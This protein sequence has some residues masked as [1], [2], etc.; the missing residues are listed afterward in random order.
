MA[1]PSLYSKDDELFPLMDKA[2]NF[3][4]SGRQVM[5]LLG[6]SGSG[7]S[8]FSRRLEQELWKQYDNSNDPIPLLISLPTIDT[9]ERD[10]VYK[11]LC[12]EGFGDSHIKDLQQ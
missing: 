6:D 2:K 9:P 5:L 11:H 1:K 12:S 3:V 4:A 7:K 10:L 8:V